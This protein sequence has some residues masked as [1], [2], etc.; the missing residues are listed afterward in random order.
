MKRNLDV[1][2]SIRCSGF[3]Q[4]RVAMT[5]GIHENTLCRMLRKDL[6]E[7]DKKKIKQALDHLKKERFE[8]LSIQLLVK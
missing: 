7:D 6:D 3:P 2:N 4:Y 8:E 1:I 5:M